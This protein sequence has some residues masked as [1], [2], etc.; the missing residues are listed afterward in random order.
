MPLNAR[1]KRLL[2]QL[3]AE[4][5]R[6]AEEIDRVV[7]EAQRLCMRLPLAHREEILREL[8]SDMHSDRLGKVLF[9]K[10]IGLSVRETASILGVSRPT[11]YNHLNRV[12]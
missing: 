8:F 7:E 4:S 5:R 3:R 2:K 6:L 12:Q 11:I 10:E 9:A 1:Q